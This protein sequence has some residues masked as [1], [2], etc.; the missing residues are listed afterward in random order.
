[1]REEISQ[2]RK[3]VS[4]YEHNDAGRYCKAVYEEIRLV[5]NSYSITE[6]SEK[7]GFGANNTMAQIHSGHRFISLKSAERIVKVFQLNR[8][9]S[10]HFLS[11]VKLKLARSPEEKERLLA[12]ILELRSRHS[13][14][15]QNS[16]GLE[17][18]NSWLHAV[19]FE[20]LSMEKAR[21]LK[22]LCERMNLTVKESAV[23]KSLEFLESINLMKK[24]LSETNEP[25]KYLKT[26]QD[27]SLG[28]EVPGL[29]IVRYHQEM[30]NLA[31]ESLIN[32][33]PSERDVSSVTISV[34][35]EQVERIKQDIALFRKYLLFLG[36]QSKVANKVMQ[37]NVQL[38][39]LSK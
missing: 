11:L 16:P 36:S 25:T 19:V 28:S 35:S 10:A 15:A 34:D 39:P 6:Y 27:F 9:E 3:R 20:L 12:L 21:S 32:S 23:L 8:S 37:V 29:A 14:S 2:I 33:P 24:I 30:L 5:Q 22:E 17:F 13:G 1:M 38:F 7:L 18:F 4:V 26:K 31:K